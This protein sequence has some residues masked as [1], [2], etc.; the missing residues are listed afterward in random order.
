MGYLLVSSNV[1]PRLVTRLLSDSDNKWQM[2]QYLNEG[3]NHVT[4][5]HTHI[6]RFPDHDVNVDVLTTFVH[7]YN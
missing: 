7:K 3:W 5:T 4:H 6:H 2:K 1:R